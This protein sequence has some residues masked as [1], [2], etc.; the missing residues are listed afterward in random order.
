MGRKLTATTK[1]MSLATLTS[2][3]LARVQNLIER[4]EALNQEIQEINRELEAIESGDRNGTQTSTPP[5]AALV[6]KTSEAK[7]ATAGQRKPTAGKTPRG[8]L[9][10]RI[11]AQLQSAGK[12]GMKV[13]DLAD[14][15]GTS[16]GN[17]TAFF[18]STAKNIKEI[19]KIGRG[20][21]AWS[22]A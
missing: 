9:K 21:Y 10:E 8:G 1:P 7:P 15:L 22:G 16:Y 14:Q 19:K 18:G 5:R 4:K 2:K 11:T 3:D 12:E 20:Q 13:S 6:P 17:V